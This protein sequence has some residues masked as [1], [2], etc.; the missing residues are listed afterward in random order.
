MTARTHPLTVTAPSS[1]LRVLGLTLAVTGLLVSMSVVAV[2]PPSA[3]AVP[4]PVPTHLREVSLASL[5]GDALTEA[6][7]TPVA[8]EAGRTYRPAKAPRAGLQSGAQRTDGRLHVVGVTWPQGAVTAQDTVEY[9]VRDAGAWSDWTAMEADE[10]HGPDPDTA[11]AR[12]ERGGTDP[13]VVTADAVD[14][15]VL[16]TSA[17]VP[18]GVQLDLIDP[19]VSAADA[20][21]SQAGSAQAAGTKPTI[22]TRAQWGADERLRTGVPEYGTIKAGF[23]HHTVNANN[24]SAGQ[25]PAIIRGIYSFHTQSRGWSDIGYNF[26]IDRFGRTWEGRAGG[27]DQPVI[28]AHT[29][30]F[31]SQLFGAAAIGTFSTAS[32]PAATMT[33]FN[34]LF[35]WKLGL[36]H[37]DP[38]A[39]VTLAGMK[40][41]VYTVSGHRDADGAPNDTECPGNALYA[42]LASIR[43]AAKSLMGAAF[44]NPTQDITSWTYGSPG[45]TIRAKPNRSMSWT[46]QVRSACRTD[47]LATAKGSATVTSGIVAPWNGKLASGAWA[48]PG[49]YLVSV[50]GSAGS[51]TANSVP[52]YTVRVHVGSAPG[53]PT[54]YCPPRIGGDDRYATAVLVARAAHPQ[55]TTVVLASGADAGMADALV[56]APLAQAKSAALLLTGPDRLPPVVQADIRA[57]RATSAYVVGGTG[58]IAGAVETQLRNLGVTTITR[59]PGK[60]RYDTAAKVAWQMGG[61][62]KDVLIASGRAD[63][64]ADGLVLSGPGAALGRPILLVAADKVPFETRWALGH[65]QAQRTVVA[66]GTGVIPAA[67]AAQLPSPTRVAGADRYGTSTAVANWASRLFPATQVLLSSGEAAALVDT[68]SGGQFGRVT[69]YTKGTSMPSTTAAWLDAAPGLREVTVLG[70]TGAV[71]ELVAGRAQRAVLQ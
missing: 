6:A 51:G 16:T 71:N 64:M 50:S 12:A 3:D 37:V 41:S 21:V 69:L 67:V 33:A 62:R 17:S 26:L 53:A 59:L 66:G 1:P 36:A 28:G 39:K 70:G 30:G 24:Y 20:P 27:V 49:D 9:R 22:L 29:G 43:T 57:R 35:A 65:V 56:A 14:V 44:F 47:V 54:G 15:R 10:D 5:S 23:V 40:T 31:N 63:A 68:L 61:V 4:H 13:Y 32:P 8:S 48:P 55:A 58:V 52:P 18:A 42:K 2:R 11:E 45:P 60:N 34:K 46:L 38:T 7:R 19:S 25:V